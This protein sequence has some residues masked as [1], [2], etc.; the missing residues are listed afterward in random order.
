MAEWIS[1]IGTIDGIDVNGSTIRSTYMGDKLVKEETIKTADDKMKE[2]LDKVTVWAEAVKKA[3]EA[4]HMYADSTVE[5]VVNLIS[6]VRIL[7]E[8]NEFSAKEC[9]EHGNC[10][11]ASV[12]SSEAR[13]KCLEVIQ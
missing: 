2:W 3:L 4:K 9:Q 8:S 13:R 5:D 1:G 7:W 11:C 12:H 6:L 10:N